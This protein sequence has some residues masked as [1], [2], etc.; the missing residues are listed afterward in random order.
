[1]D[2]LA[3][4]FLPRYSNNHKAKILHPSSLLIL[5]LLFGIFQVILSL[6]PPKQT[7]VLGYAA[8]IS[9]SDV[10]KFTNEKRAESGLSP[11]TFNQLL[12]DA[13]LEKGHYMID[14]DF[15]AHVAPDGTEPWFFFQK[16]GYKYRYAGENL[17]R[18]FSNA[19]AAVDAW[20]ASP[21]H[22]ENMLSPKYKD[23]G[24]AVV[25]GD[26]AGSDTTIVVQLFGTTLGDASSIPVA[27]AQTN[28]SPTAKPGKV[29]AANVSP[30]V[31]ITLTPT[32]TPQEEPTTVIAPDPQQLVTNEESTESASSVRLFLSQFE[33]TRGISLLVLGLLFIVTAIDAVIIFIKN[34]RRRGGRSFAHLAFFGM[35]IIVVVIIRAGKIL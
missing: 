14:H 22:R 9:V 29:A 13:A 32:A 23:I 10:I 4:L 27:K 21:S 26:L 28:V 16:H 11:V 33:T 7:A 17:A 24:V 6:R 12:T 8:Q 5:A 30:V 35:I 34:I 3:H 1:M 25:E 31:T 18:D 15:W 19:S 20:M 2:T